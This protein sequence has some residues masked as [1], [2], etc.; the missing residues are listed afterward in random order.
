MRESMNDPA[1]PSDA[2]LARLDANQDLLRF[3]HWWSSWPAATM[4]L[5]AVV[6]RDPVPS[7][8]LAPSLVHWIGGLSPLSR[9]LISVDEVLITAWPTLQG[10]WR[11]AAADRPIIREVYGLPEPPPPVT[12]PRWPKGTPFPRA[13]TPSVEEAV[14]VARMA[15]EVAHIENIEFWGS[16][17][18]YIQA[19]GAFGAEVGQVGSLHGRSMISF[20][21]DRTVTSNFG[22]SVIEASVPADQLVHQ[23]LTGA[24]ESEVLI[25]HMLKVS[26]SELMEL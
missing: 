15:S 11:E 14:V 2:A 23:T 8:T 16:L 20:T 3:A 7:A 12:A 18:Y 19:H 1:D 4:Q 6:A 13:A 17:E 21:T 10:P 22:R 24:N 26:R 5:L 9:V 25:F